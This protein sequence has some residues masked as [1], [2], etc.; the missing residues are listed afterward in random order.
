[1]QDPTG[2]PPIPKVVPPPADITRIPPPPYIG[3]ANAA[4]DRIINAHQ[5]PEQGQKSTGNYTAKSR[6]EG[7][8]SRGMDEKARGLRSP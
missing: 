3:N 4:H 8:L 1:M 5:P 7:H 6:Y 2:K